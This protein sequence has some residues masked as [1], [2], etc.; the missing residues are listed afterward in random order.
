VQTKAQIE[1]TLHA[2][3]KA[4]QEML[5]LMRVQH[6]RCVS[7]EQRLTELEA[8]VTAALTVELAEG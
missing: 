8:R 1:K 5:G 7:L 2:V 4:Q 3:V 6:D